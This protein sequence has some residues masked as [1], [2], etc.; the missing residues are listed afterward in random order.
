MNT[1]TLAKQQ[2]KKE[3]PTKKGKLNLNKRTPH[4]HKINRT[5]GMINHAS[6]NLFIY[7]GSG[8]R[9]LLWANWQVYE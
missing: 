4:L 5:L 9:E 1:S 7:S 6:K 2:L 8:Q 3:R